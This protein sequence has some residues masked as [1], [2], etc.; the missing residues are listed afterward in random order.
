[1]RPI[2][3][4]GVA[5]S[6][7]RFDVTIV[8]STKTAEPIEMQFG[9]WTLVGPRNHGSLGPWVQIFPCEGATLRVKRAP[10]VKYRDSLPRA[11]NKRLH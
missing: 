2:D 10:I 3:T 7:D 11:V 9:L 1:M 8:S 5:W 4:D 6:V